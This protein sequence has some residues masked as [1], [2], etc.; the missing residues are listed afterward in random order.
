MLISSYTKII[1]RVPVELGSLFGM[2]SNTRFWLFDRPRGNRSDLHI[3]KLVQDCEGPKPDS[4]H[5]LMFSYDFS[6]VPINYMTKVLSPRLYGTM[7]TQSRQIQVKKSVVRR[8]HTIFR[9]KLAGS[10]GRGVTFVNINNQHTRFR[11]LYKR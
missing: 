11:T 10:P 9:S 6:N 1:K 8:L 4:R 5:V 2:V 7:C 3:A